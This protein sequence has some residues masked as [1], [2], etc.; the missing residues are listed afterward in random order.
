M[1]SRGPFQP[2]HFC[3]SVKATQYFFLKVPADLITCLDLSNFFTAVDGMPVLG[4][5]QRL[6][7]PRKSHDSKALNTQI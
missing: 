6:L 1:I 4:H 5:F 7:C 2:L 3:D